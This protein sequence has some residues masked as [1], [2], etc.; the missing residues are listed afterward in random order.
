MPLRKSP[1]RT[2]ALLA[3]NRRNARKSTGPRTPIGKWHC[4][5]NAVRHYR[6]TRPSSCIPIENREIEA[7]EDFYFNLREAIIPAENAAGAEAVLVN[8]ARAWKV[9]CL[10]DRWIE[11]R[12]EEDWLI[13]AAGAAPPPSFWRLRLR[14]LGVSVP[15]WTVTISVWRRWGRGAGLSR[16]SAVEDDAKPDRPR[17]HTMVSVHSTGPSRRAV[18][19]E[20]EPRQPKCER[21]KP[22]CHTIQSS[23]GNMTLP[24]DREAAFAAG[25]A[26]A[27]RLSI[28]SRYGRSERS[29]NPI[30][31]KPFP[32]T[33]RL[34]GGTKAIARPGRNANRGLR[35]RSPRGASKRSQNISEKKALAE[36]SRKL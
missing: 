7:L 16:R 29:R 33:Y 5:R 11:T 18:A 12:T 30:E 9:K 26:L 15:D 4:A 35:A 36:L 2:R 10:L 31:T 28:G 27:D 25:Y 22:E 13:P 21:T 3:A 6:R 23:S 34:R 8:A 14:R 19:R 24:G 1:R 20:G 32:K 17:M